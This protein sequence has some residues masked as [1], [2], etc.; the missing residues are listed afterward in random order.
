MP[1]QIYKI[2]QFHGGLSTNSD[3]RDIAD[4]ELSE[5]TDV[6]VDE[7]GK[8]RMM[9]G[10][11]A[12]G[13]A[14]RTNV[15]NPGYGLFQ[16]SHDRIDGHTVGSGV[17]TG[18][19]YLV[20]SDSSADELIT[21]TK[22]R[23][24]SA[25]SDWAVLNIAGGSLTEP[26][27]KLQVVTTTDEEIEGAQLAVARLSETIVVGATYRIS[28]KLDQT[29][30]ATTPVINFSLGG[31][32]T[33]ITATDGSPSDSTIDTTEQEYYGDVVP[34]NTTGLLQI[35][36]TSLASTTTFKID[37]ISVKA[38]RVSIYSAEDTTWGNPITGLSDNTGGLRKDAFYAADGA[39][40]ISDGEFG[41]ANVNKWYGYTYAKLFQ[42][43][44]G[45]EELEL[46]TW[47]LQDQKLKSFTDLSIDVSI[48]DCRV[49]SPALAALTANDIVLGWWT[50]EDGE[51]D[52]TYTLGVNPVYIGGQEGPITEAG[53]IQLFNHV[54]FVQVFVCH[55]TID[56]TTISVHPFGDNRIIGINLYRRSYPSENWYLLEE[57]DLKTGGKHGWSQYVADTDLAKGRWTD[58]TDAG[59]TD[60]SVNDSGGATEFNDGTSQ[61]IAIRALASIN[62]YADTTMDLGVHG[63]TNMGAGRIG[64]ARITGFG[65]TVYKEIS[66]SSTSVQVFTTATAITVTNPENGNK[67]KFT[68]EILDENYGLLVKK[69]QTIEIAVDA[70]A[71]P[72]SGYGG[73]PSG[74]SGGGSG[75]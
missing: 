38:G 10:T 18:T 5:A 15:I 37:D 72:S 51:W 3:P 35:Y 13:A 56:N 70:D 69:V 7:L 34:I 61:P 32:A 41:N 22:N 30:G 48:D 62:E 28:A 71:E 47:S 49:A 65:S 8:V 25:A 43:T 67:K 27:N 74:G 6:M 57:I 19:D 39:L 55:P 53:V 54:L 66:L 2:D 24:F 73:A 21:D 4:N 42:T 17:E 1:K 44:D 45:S 9:G 46:D 23:D 26:S 29:S 20:F 11:A 14:A 63:G 33:T 50:E 52:G 60:S 58:G 31:T 59:D 64:I 40:R 36:N 12:Q 16:F 68:L 75:S